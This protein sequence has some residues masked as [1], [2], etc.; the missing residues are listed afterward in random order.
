MHAVGQRL[1]ERAVGAGECIQIATGAPMPQGADAVVM[2]EYTAEVMPGTIEV[3]RPVAPGEGV[4]RADEDARPGDEII[5]R[6]RPL[7]PQDLGMLAA[8]GV[9]SS[10][11]FTSA[12]ALPKPP[13]RS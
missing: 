11:L 10:G 4:V 12:R 13:T 2:V 6:G 7:R 5:A 8:A 1:D 9:T 3:V